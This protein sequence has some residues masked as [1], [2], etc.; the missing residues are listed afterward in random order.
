MEGQSLLPEVLPAFPSAC[1]VHL[2]LI[3]N[4]ITILFIS[5]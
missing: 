2:E 5:R 4:S 1:L 3:M